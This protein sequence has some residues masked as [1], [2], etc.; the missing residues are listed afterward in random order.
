VSSDFKVIFSRAMRARQV[1]E[2][3]GGCM[4]QCYAWEVR[5]YATLE[6]IIDCMT[7]MEL[8]DGALHQVWLG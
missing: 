7:K 4:G 8:V 2:W 1:K 3:L 6:A 5:M